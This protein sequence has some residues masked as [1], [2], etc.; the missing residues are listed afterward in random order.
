MI[1]VEKTIPGTPI[2]CGSYDCKQILLFDIETTGLSAS[3]SYLYLIGCS[4]YSEDGYQLIQWFAENP[5]E[6]LELLKQFVTFATSFSVCIHFNGNTFDIPY[7]TH[8]CRSYNLN[9]CFT[10]FVS[11]DLYRVARGLKSLLGLSRCNQTSMEERIGLKRVD[12]LNGRELIRIYTE[13]VGLAKLEQLQNQRAV[14]SFDQD[15]PNDPNGHSAKDRRHLMLLHNEEDLLGLIK[16]T[17]L[18]HYE[19]CFTGDY[20]I[21]NIMLD[22]QNRICFE[23]Q[24]KEPFPIPFEYEKESL[25]LS[26]S[27]MQC[28]LRIP[29]F[30]G[31]L[32]HYIEDYKNYFYLPLEDTIVH[33]SIAGS[34]DSSYRVRATK[35]TCYVK[36]TALF[37]PQ[38]RPLITPVFQQTRTDGVLYFECSDERLLDETFLRMYIKH[39]LADAFQLIT[40]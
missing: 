34:M 20:Q 39:L 23:L 13:Y 9:P 1:T 26:G 36:K 2:R 31:T 12:Q 18:L 3:K 6:E 28:T 30:E 16:L 25:Q 17:S 7:L 29:L 8:K 38:Y 10:E 33:K 22:A 21:Q 35:D 19:Q 11:I 4:Y 15:S 24:A 32:K 27:E 14:N 37:L 40:V 5:N